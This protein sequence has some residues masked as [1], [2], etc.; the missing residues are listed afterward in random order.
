MSDSKAEKPY[1]PLEA[2]RGMRDAG[3]DAWAKVMTDAVQTDTYAQ[4]S[5]AILDAYLTTS[6]PFHEFVQK[7]ITRSLQELNLP[8]RVELAALSERLTNIEF[9]LDDMDVKLDQ[10]VA[11]LPDSAPAA[12]KTNRKEGKEHHGNRSV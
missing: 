9:R 6:A 1:D 10:I 8:S 7:V 12:S 5:G 3:M 2:W 4:T 11:K